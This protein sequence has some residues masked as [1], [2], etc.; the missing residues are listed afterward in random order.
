MGRLLKEIDDRCDDRST[1]SAGFYIEADNPR[2]KIMVGV[3]CRIHDFEESDIALLDT[4]AQWSVIGGE[5]AESSKTMPLN[6]E[7]SRL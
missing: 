6:K 5:V 7:M 2:G 1:G 4:S 3:Q